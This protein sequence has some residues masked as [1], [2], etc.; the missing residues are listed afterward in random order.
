MT[1]HCLPHRHQQLDFFVTDITDAAHKADIASMEHPL[2][3][4]KSGDRRVRTYTRNGFDGDRQAE[5]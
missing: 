2:F 5:K 4:L 3:A 1:G